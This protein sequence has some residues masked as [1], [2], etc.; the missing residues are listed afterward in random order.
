MGKWKTVSSLKGRTRPA[1]VIAR[2]AATRRAN[3]GPWHNAATRL[4]LKSAMTG[5]TLSQEHKV[6]IRS[7]SGGWH[8]TDET[9]RHLRQVN[10][11]RSVS[12]ETREKLSAAVKGK[13][14]TEIHGDNADSV[15]L[16]IS[17]AHRMK[18]EG[19]R[20]VDARPYHGCAE[21]KNW[22]TAVF[23]RDNFTCKKC[24]KRDGQPLQAH[25]IKR[26]IEFPD[27]RFVVSNGITLCEDPCHKEVDAQAGARINLRF[28]KI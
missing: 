11:G 12:V 26:W 14:Y 1:E 22:R 3:G 15:A 6:K 28:K 21:Y 2:I 7:S 9:K 4:K 25:H 19:K 5:R 27:L 20:R 18:W 24:G 10:L 16:K 17:Q 13:T 8:H 23:K